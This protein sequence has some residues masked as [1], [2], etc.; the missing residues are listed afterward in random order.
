MVYGLREG[1]LSRLVEASST[2]SSRQEQGCHRVLWLISRF[3]SSGVLL[4]VIPRGTEDR[5]GLRETERVEQAAGR[6]VG[7]DEAVFCG[8]GSADGGGVGGRV[9]SR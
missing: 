8:G 4:L 5:E 9:D 6:V 3:E 2:R 1:L 7:C